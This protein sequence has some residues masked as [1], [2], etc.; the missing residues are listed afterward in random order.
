MDTKTS[1]DKKMFIGSVEGGWGNYKKKTTCGSPLYC[2][3]STVVRTI[4][5]EEDEE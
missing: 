2:G 5:P 3:Q 1:F 4:Y